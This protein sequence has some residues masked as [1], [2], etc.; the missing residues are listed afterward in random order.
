ML[1]LVPIST[2]ASNHGDTS[3]RFSVS[4][5]N[6]YAYTGS[7]S[8]ENTTS[9]YVNVEQVPIT[10]IYADVQGYRPSSV[11]GTNYWV[12]ETLGG[13]KVT[14]SKGKWLVKQ[15]VYENGGRSARL[16]F[17]RYYGTGTVSGVWSPDS[18]GSYPYAN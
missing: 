14:L 3:F 2:F 17:Q 15:L 18:V 13:D 7:R 9:T 4:T 16:K 1:T 12:D 5:S 8:K 10:Y 11:S 6:N